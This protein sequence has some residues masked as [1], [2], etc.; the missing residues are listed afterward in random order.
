MNK[1]KN[2]DIDKS[3][4]MES[5][6]QFYKLCGLNEWSYMGNTLEED[7]ETDG[8]ELQPNNEPQEQT[9]GEESQMNGDENLDMSNEAMPQDDMSQDMGETPQQDDSLVPTDDNILDQEGGEE[10]DTDE[11]DVTDLTD[12]QEELNHKINSVGKDINAT[13][14]N[15]NKMMS[16]LKSITKVIDNNNKKIEELHAEI[17]KRN[18]T[19]LEKLDLRS[20]D[21][22]APYNVRPND[23]WKKFMETNPNYTEFDENDPNNNSNEKKEYVITTDDIDDSDSFDVA[24]S[25]DMSDIDL[26]KI[27][28]L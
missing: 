26:E 6:K 14:A 20:V 1:K 7:E 3:W 15:I 9:N 22:S 28:G 23:Y 10:E 17:E 2:T 11:L 24:K 5:R 27:F 25:F 18:P 16:M 13:D 21:T 19:P 8:E 12:A 4:L